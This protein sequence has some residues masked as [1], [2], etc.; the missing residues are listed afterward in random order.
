M[1]GLFK[2]RVI[3]SISGKSLLIQFPDAGLDGMRCD[4]DSNL[5]ITRSNKGNGGRRFTAG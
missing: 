5:F 4:V 2:S 1:S 3:G